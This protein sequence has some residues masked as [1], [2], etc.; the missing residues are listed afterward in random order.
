MIK[1]QRWRPDTSD[2]IIEYHYDDTQP[3]RPILGGSQEEQPVNVVIVVTRAN[4]HEAISEEQKYNAIRDENQLKNKIEREILEN[5]PELVEQN[6][7]GGKQIKQGYK[8]TFSFDSQRKIHVDVEGAT[9]LQKS[10]IQTLKSN[11][12]TVQIDIKKNRVK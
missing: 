11:Q 6:E 9:A 3:G 4:D 8:Y 5:I 12:E 2:S 7:N 1:I 10:I